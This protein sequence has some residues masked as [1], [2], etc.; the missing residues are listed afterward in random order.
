MMKRKSMYAALSVAF[1]AF[2][3]P[4]L[5]SPEAAAQATAQVKEGWYKHLVGFDAVKPHA[6]LPQDDKATLLVDS[7]PAARRYDIGH[8]PLAVNIPETQFDKLAPTMLPANKAAPIIFYCQG[9]ECDLSHKSAFKAEALGYTNIKVYPAGQPEWEAKGELV[10]VSVAHIK[11]LMAE[12]GDFALIDARPE[13]AFGQGTIPGAINVPD[14]KFDKE[15]AKLPA[16]K[17]TTLIFFCGG[18]KC[19]LSSKAAVKARNLG[20]KKVFI[21]PEGY[22]GWQA[23]QPA[24]GGAPVAIEGGKEK[25]S[26]SIA[27]FERLLKD[28]PSQVMVVDVRDEKVFLKGSFPG[29]VNLPINDLEKK[30]ASLPKDKPVVFVCA[31]GA[32]SGEAYDTVMTLGAGIKAYFLDAEVNFLG[33]GKYTIKGK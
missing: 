10:A 33:D 25:G 21:Y 6:E 16:N 12:K 1:L 24:A 13:R 17:E 20:Y 32:R 14:T 26:I 2:A 19:D 31:T 22:P 27:S 23:S 5:H 3:I 4:A 11:K 18:V 30:M 7:R 15:S 28:T 9:V 8:I 29:A